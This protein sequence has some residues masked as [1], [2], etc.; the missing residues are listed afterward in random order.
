MSAVAKTARCGRAEAAVRLA[1]AGAYL[2]AARMVLKEHDVDEYL[3]VASGNAVLA[4]IAASD[5]ICCLRLGRMHRGPD[6]VGAVDLLVTAI[7]D[8]K[9][10]SQTLVRLLN[11]KDEA[12]YG[13]I[14]ASSRKANDA[15]KW[16]AALIA[17]AHEEIER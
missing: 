1:V 12:H 8:G 9:K 11:L 7:P 13:V 4:G 14:M 5:S 17:R 15:V 10:A 6:H 3:S 2:E 16:A